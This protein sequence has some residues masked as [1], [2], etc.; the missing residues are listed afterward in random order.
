MPRSGLAGLLGLASA[1]VSPAIAVAVAANNTTQVLD[2]RLRR[3][4]T[5]RA[6]AGC[7]LASLL[8]AS[9]SPVVFL[10]V[11]ALAVWHRRLLGVQTQPV[12][13]LLSWMLG[14]YAAGDRQR[15]FRD[16]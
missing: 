11:A 13:L 14:K 12:S 10:V 7:F 3:P 1:G 4:G 6:S 2:V 9:H 8:I 5:G 15:R 16:R